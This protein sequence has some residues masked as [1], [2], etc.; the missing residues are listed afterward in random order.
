MCE[1]VISFRNIQQ[2]LSFIFSSFH[3]M[4]QS[5]SNFSISSLFYRNQKKEKKKKNSFNCLLIWFP[6]SVFEAKSL[7][8]TAQR[9]E[10]CTSPLDS[11]PD[12]AYRLAV[13]QT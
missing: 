3:F 12:A 5:F 7:Y 4:V 2:K 10:L 11:P 8:T 6:G 1:Y 13:G 9:A